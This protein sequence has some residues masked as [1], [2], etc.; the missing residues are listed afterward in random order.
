[1]IFS[2]AKQLKKWVRKTQAVRC[3]AESGQNRR[4][5]VPAIESLEE[6]AVPAIVFGQFNNDDFADM[7]YSA[8]NIGDEGKVFVLYGT[9]NGLGNGW[10]WGKPNKVLSQGG[11]FPDPYEMTVGDTIEQGDNFG[12][13]LTVGDFNGDTFDDLAIGVPGEDN[14]A[15]A[16]HIVYGSANGLTKL[17]KQFFKQSALISV[18]G[19]S[20]SNDAFGSAL[21][22]GDF[23]GDGFDDLA[24][25]VPGENQGA[26]EVNILYGDGTGLQLSSGVQVWSQNNILAV[27]EQPVEVYDPYYGTTWE[28]GTPAQAGDHFG[29]VL[30]AGDFMGDGADDLV[31]GAPNDDVFHQGDVVH[32]AGTVAAIYGFE[33]QGLGGWYG[34][35]QQGLYGLAGVPEGGDL[36][37]SALAVG[38]FNGDGKDDL[39]LGVPGED[40]GAGLGVNVSMDAA[41]SKGGAGAVQVIYGHVGQGW[42]VFTSGLYTQAGP[43][44]QWLQGGAAGAEFGWALAAGDFDGNGADDLAV[45]APGTADDSGAVH[46]IHGTDDDYAG[47]SKNGPIAWKTMDRDSADILGMVVA[48]ERFGAYLGAGDIDYNGH[49]DLAVADDSSSLPYQDFNVIYG[50]DNGLEAQPAGAPANALWTMYGSGPLKKLHAFGDLAAL[51][52]KTSVSLVPGFPSNAAGPY[53]P[54]GPGSSWLAGAQ[55]Q[56]GPRTIDQKVRSNGLVSVPSSSALLPAVQAPAAEWFDPKGMA[57]SVLK[58][59]A[60]KKTR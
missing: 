10:G 21:A 26:G 56:V 13:A 50:A 46:V 58:A 22:S 6:R 47:L 42:A 27:P 34:Y 44:N 15:G 19:L 23:D 53:T 52:F 36:F 40:T 1:M 11:I 18:G 8:D 28:P 4:R 12:K 41:N 29:A 49:A 60:Q 30:A 24:I 5:V 43:G 2:F 55:A 31:I 32:N 35:F 9:A 3:G 38:D 25:G 51:I 16:V 33:N 59:P 20:E 17:G 45:G 39:A 54:F 14:G 7:A 57:A 48:G 37:G